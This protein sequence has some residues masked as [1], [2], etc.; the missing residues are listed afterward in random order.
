VAFDFML[1]A[2]SINSEKE[3]FMQLKENRR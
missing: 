2:Y 1:S 3:K